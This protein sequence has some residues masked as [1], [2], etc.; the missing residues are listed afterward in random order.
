MGFLST[1]LGRRG[2]SAWAPF[3]SEAEYE[4]FIG[5]TARALGPHSASLSL[6]RGEAKLRIDGE[7]QSI[8][9][10]ELARKCHISDPQHWDEVVTEHVD[11]LLNPKSKALLAGLGADFAKAQALLKAQL[12][13]D[14]FVRPDW[15]QGENYQAL[16][17]GLNIALVY[18]LPETVTTVPMEHF[19]SWAR[20]FVEV[21]GIA[22]SNVKGVKPALVPEQTDSA[23]SV[24]MLEGESFFVCSHALWVH[25]YPQARS[26]HGV[27][28]TVPSRHVVQ[29]HPIRDARAYEAMRVL[30]LTARTLVSELPFPI[31]AN[32]FWSRGGKISPVPFSFFDA[33]GVPVLVSDDA[34]QIAQMKRFLSLLGQPS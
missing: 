15:V 32:V 33:Q 22:I 21:L 11:R 27:L 24:L 8:S 23:S 20:P 9:L 25:E 5:L 29:F 30:A 17:G 10:R 6:N 14:S 2:R 13:P 19:R 12:V 26:D 1:L 4:R 18:D 7:L 34:K 16:G 3:F 28:F 31:S